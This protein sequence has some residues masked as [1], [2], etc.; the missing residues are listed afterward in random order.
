[1]TSALL[2]IVNSDAPERAW[3]MI[4]YYFFSTLILLP[5]NYNHGSPHTQ[6][7]NLGELRHYS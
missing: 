3:F 6:K 1:M 7:K 2:F 5:A 4:N